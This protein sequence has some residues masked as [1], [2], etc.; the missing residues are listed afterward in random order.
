MH[1]SQKRHRKTRIE[2]SAFSDCCIWSIAMVW[3][4]TDTSL[5]I[6]GVRMTGIDL[7]TLIDEWLIK[8]VTVI[9]PLPIKTQE[10]TSAKMSLTVIKRDLSQGACHWCKWEISRQSPFKLR[11]SY[12]S[13]L[14]LTDGERFGVLSHLDPWDLLASRKL[15]K[16]W[17][18]TTTPPPP[19][20]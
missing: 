18:T 19:H 6:E 9:P 4:T 15:T 17:D 16:F 20:L 1:I 3:W 14:L 2:D 11:E 10:T 12:R 7:T 5:K 8:S 13:R